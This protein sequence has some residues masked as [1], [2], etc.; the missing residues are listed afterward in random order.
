[1]WDWLKYTIR[2]NTINYSK[3]IAK[4]RRGKLQELEQR[5]KKDEEYRVTSP[6]K[7]NL[8]VLENKRLSTCNYEKEFNHIEQDSIIRS[9]IG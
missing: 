6:T 8:E 4:K 2:Y 9:L 3:Q 5:L 7:E 1:M